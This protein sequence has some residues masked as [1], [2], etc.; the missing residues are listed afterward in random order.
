MVAFLPS[1][2]LMLAVVLLVPLAVLAAPVPVVALGVLSVVALLLAGFVIDGLRHPGPKLVEIERELPRALSVGEEASIRLR[3]R[4]CGDVPL[5]ARVA[6]GCPP[7]LDPTEEILEVELPPHTWVEECYT[8]KPLSRGAFGFGPIQL[9]L[10]RRLGLAE[11]Q[12]SVDVESEARVHPNLR[13][14]ARWELR[15]RRD[16]LHL[17]GARRTRLLGREGD[18]ERL[19]DFVAG[20]DIRHV[21]WKA[22]ARQRRPITRVYQAEKAQTLLI[23]VDATR[24]MAS[25]AAGLTKMDFAVNAALMLAFVGLTRGDRVGVAVFD[26]GVRAYLP[27]QLGHAQFGRILDLLFDQ[28]PSRSFPRYREAARAIARDHRRRSLVVWLTDLL[29]GEQGRELLAALRALRGRH[30]SLVVAMDDPDVHA[31][32]DQDPV[33]PQALFV[34][35]GAAELLDERAALVRRLMAEGAHVVDRRPEEITAALVDQ[36]LHLKL[37]GA[38]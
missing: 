17:G 5:L 16:L 23:M 32:A 13:N 9:R 31:L 10:K 7:P 35:V 6:D 37:R 14:L 27:P 34:R 4:N 8:V 26:D 25:R 24:L 36:Y 12:L 15:A 30:L 18:F 3:L 28:Q 29:D 33:D 1:R 19:R 20:D 2:R 21:D 22:T 11:H 38:L